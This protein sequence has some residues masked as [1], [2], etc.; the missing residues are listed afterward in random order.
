MVFFLAIYGFAD[1]VRNGLLTTATVKFYAG[2]SPERSAEVLGSVW[3]LALSLSGLLAL[4]N[5]AAIPFTGYIQNH[6]YVVLIQWFGLTV[7]SS[8]PF[9]L[10]F[11]IMIADNDYTTILKLRLINSGS[12]ILVIII[13]AFV[14]KATLENIL[15]V[16]FLT[17]V[18]TSAVCLFFGYARFNTLFKR[19]KKCTAE[20]FAFGKFSLAS[21]VSSYLLGAANTL[22][23]N[24]MLGTA[25][26]AVFTIPN[27]LMEIVEIPLRSFVGT[28]MSAMATA[29]NNNNMYHL[30][31]VSKKYAGMLT[32]VFIPVAIITF[33]GADLAVWLLGGNKYTGGE[34]ANIL[35]VMMF[36]AILYPI[37]PL[38]ALR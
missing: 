32:L 17:N 31:F 24:G 30:T 20:L 3:F 29:Y 19:T 34:A 8:V 22:I 25:A 9:N 12:M 7:L 11:W 36:I 38:T 15:L 26:L 13:L 4:V 18:L 23:V 27:K 2:T 37:D 5:L 28:G 6:E 33:F 1:A 16:N 14:H 35:R 21:N 10:A